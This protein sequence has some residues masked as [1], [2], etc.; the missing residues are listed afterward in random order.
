MF[1]HS[2]AGP[3]YVCGPRCA[4]GAGRESARRLID[5]RA[6]A[7][8]FSGPVETRGDWRDGELGLPAGRAMRRTWSLQTH[9]SW[10]S[11]GGPR[12]WSLRSVKPL[13]IADCRRR[14][15]SRLSWGH[16]PVSGASSL[17]HRQS[18][19]IISCPWR[20]PLCISHD[21]QLYSPIKAAQK[22]SA[23]NQRANAVQ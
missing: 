16:V 19:V 22:R 21:N 7:T 10:R 12:R 6:P 4:R 9:D 18:H 15:S 11:V 13:V 8:F 14:A 2:L 23:I 3:L 1:R 17:L 5:S 20:L